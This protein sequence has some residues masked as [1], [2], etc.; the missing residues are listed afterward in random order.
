[1]NSWMRLRP[2]W[3]VTLA[4]VRFQQLP[5]IDPVCRPQQH[6]FWSR[7]RTRFWLCLLQPRL[8]TSEEKPRLGSRGL[9]LDRVPP[10]LELQLQRELDL[11]RGRG[12]RLNDPARGA[13]LG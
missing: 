12:S 9:G 8:S 3:P 5:V 4:P 6:H 10:I 7:L 13:V 2:R 11:P 1:M